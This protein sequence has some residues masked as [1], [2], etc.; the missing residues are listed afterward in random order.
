MSATTATNVK[1]LA[2]DLNLQGGI[3]CPNPKAHMK[4]WDSHPKVYLDVGKL[5]AVPE[6]ASPTRRLWEGTR[7]VISTSLYPQSPEGSTPCAVAVAPDGKTLFVANA[8][9][10]S[11]VVVDI[12]NRLV[13]EGHCAVRQLQDGRE[14]PGVAPVQARV[15]LSSCS[16]CWL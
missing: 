5:E 16:V 7:E 4:I 15:G 10:N 1:L 8:D 13:E 2:A 6:A 3:F 12:S 14:V 11:V 9:N